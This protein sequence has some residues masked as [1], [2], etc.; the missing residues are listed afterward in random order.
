MKNY[1]LYEK[2]TAF[3]SDGASA[4]CSQNNGVA[5]LF[6]DDNP[7]LIWIHCFTHLINLVLSDLVDECEEIKLIGS[8]GA[9]C[10]KIR[11]KILKY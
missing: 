11:L 5:G 4:L 3:C 1:E 8:D 9:K 6:Q 10:L 7:K 2:L